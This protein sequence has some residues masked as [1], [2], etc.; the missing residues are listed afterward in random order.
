MSLS[1]YL[2]QDV[3]AS[4]I[5]EHERRVVG[6]FDD[7]GLGKTI[8]ALE[9]A[10]R[11][12]ARSVLVVA[13]AVVLWNWRREVE[14]WFDADVVV[15]TKPEDVR[16]ARVVIVSRDRIRNSEMLCALLK[17]SWSML[18]ADEAHGFKEPTAKRTQ[19]FVALLNR[20]ERALWVTATPVPNHPGELWTF[21]RAAAPDRIAQKGGLR[22]VS[23]ATF[24]HRYCNVDMF[25]GVR[26]AK[27]VAELR[28]RCR[29]L[30]LRRRLT[31]V[32]D[33]PAV[34]H[35]EVVVRAE[36]TTLTTSLPTETEWGARF[37]ADPDAAL[38]A[39][40]RTEDFSTW[41][42]LCGEAK[43][44]PVA[45]LIAQ[46]IHS[47][48][49]KLVVMVHHRSVGDAI[50]TQLDAYGIDVMSISGSTPPHV[51][52]QR[53]ERFQTDDAARVIVCNIVAG[54]VGITL[55]AAH[56]LL[57]VELSFVPGE[58]MQ[59]AGR[60][61]RIGQTRPVRIRY[62]VLD[63]SIDAR[64]VSTLKRKIRDIRDTVTYDDKP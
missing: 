19:A 50:A 16:R 17:R 13:P 56:E 6:L 46:E 35:E 2:H 41:R 3:G 61:R 57:F 12:N 54:G 47:G 15:A 63:R 58:N 42:R 28:Q 37:D 52:T 53:V 49:R 59:A 38:A 18:I 34:R 9:A 32:I 10:R 27:N 44:S 64:I 60:I 20:A 43:A 23:Y 51:R 26:G 21:L 39:L 31:D 5:V 25:G 62:A 30:W 40:E 36:V 45:E 7:L 11:L 4:W 29:G 55:T 33:L 48:L 24:L 22:A 8:T 1:L 14:L